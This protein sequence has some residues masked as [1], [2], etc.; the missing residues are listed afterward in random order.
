MS[1]LSR[2]YPGEY[3]KRIS[4]REYRDYLQ[5]QIL[6]IQKRAPEDTEKFIKSLVSGQT[7]VPENYISVEFAKD[8]VLV[9]IRPPE[10]V[11]TAEIYFLLE[12]K[13]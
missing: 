13:P 2:Y 10:P 9:S 6:L 7:G 12:G 1:D 11:K 5:S 3:A 8:E 4:A